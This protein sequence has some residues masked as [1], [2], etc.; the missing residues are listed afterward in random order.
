M[1]LVVWGKCD[2]AGWLHA[3]LQSSFHNACT[4][5]HVLTTRQNFKMTDEHASDI[6]QEQ[7][8]STNNNPISSIQE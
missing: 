1:V 5:Y 6:I 4:L 2:K 8:I 3:G 7:A